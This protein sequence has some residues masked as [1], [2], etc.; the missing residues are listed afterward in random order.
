MSR[1]F[2]DHY[3]KKFWVEADW[4]AWE[5]AGRPRVPRHLDLQ[6]PISLER[7]RELVDEASKPLEPLVLGIDVNPAGRAC[8]AA[9]G[10]REDGRVH[11]GLIASD[12][13]VEGADLDTPGGLYER[14]RTFVR[15]PATDYRVLVD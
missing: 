13:Q 9:A 2:W 8:F 15:E 7:W 5:K 4:Q 11:V 1:G 3:P 14:L 10:K 6:P 12:L